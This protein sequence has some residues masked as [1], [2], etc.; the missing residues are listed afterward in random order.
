MKLFVYKTLFIFLCI[1][2][3]YK[4][5]FGSLIKNFENKIESIKSKESIFEIKEK[6]RGEM[7]GAI[8]KDKILNKEDAILINKFLRKIENELSNL[9]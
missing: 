4:L 7:R 1:L 8:K 9:N 6:I 3:T 2:I 5:T